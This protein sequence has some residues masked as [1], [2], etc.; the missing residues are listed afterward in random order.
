MLPPP[1]LNI[2]LVLCREGI[3]DEG[4]LL[5]RPERKIIDS[6]DTLNKNDTQK[7]MLD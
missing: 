6:G 3:K 1:R 7:A 5:L 2:N 4:P